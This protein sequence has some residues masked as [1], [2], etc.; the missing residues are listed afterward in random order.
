[1]VMLAGRG[2]RRTARPQAEMAGGG[3]WHAD[4]ARGYP[5]VSNII[6]IANGMLTLAR[7]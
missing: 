2:A 7:F 1:M 4:R 6:K 5:L 3:R